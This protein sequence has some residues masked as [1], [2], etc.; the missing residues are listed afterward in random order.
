MLDAS[1][2]QCHNDM[3]VFL[4]MKEQNSGSALTHGEEAGVLADRTG[5][6]YDGHRG[7]A[8]AWHSKQ[9]P[10]RFGKVP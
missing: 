1:K 10:P 4:L 2:N 5:R 8:G 6:S 3:E 9:A 7:W